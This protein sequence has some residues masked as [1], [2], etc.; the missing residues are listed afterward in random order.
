[1]K[2]LGIDNNQFIFISKH[3][4]AWNYHDIITCS[5]YIK[6]TCITILSWFVFDRRSTY[7]NENKTYVILDFFFITVFYYWSY[8]VP[9]NDAM[10]DSGFISAGGFS[11]TIFG[12]GVL[13]YASKIN[14]CT[15]NFNSAFDFWSLIFFNSF[16]M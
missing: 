13:N 3:T 8:S 2:R 1:M 7:K 6:H 5:M 12:E 11:E 4:T 16:A 10:W 14:C 15:F 9:I